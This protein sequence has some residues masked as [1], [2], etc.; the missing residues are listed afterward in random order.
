MDDRKVQPG[1]ETVWTA[2]WVFAL[3]GFLVLTLTA[4]MLVLLFPDILF[5]VFATFGS[6]GVFVL[7]GI[8][9]ICL[10]IALWL[11]YKRG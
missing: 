9:A 1:K 11:W 7:W 2:L 5:L 10:A 6:T 4:V 3:G 8:A